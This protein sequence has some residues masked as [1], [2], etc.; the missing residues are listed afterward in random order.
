MI[1]LDL[2]D[3]AQDLQG[4]P[5]DGLGPFHGHLSCPAEVPYSGARGVTQRRPN[6]NFA[7]Q[8]VRYK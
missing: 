8:P 1:A 3:V 6:P 5:A 4:G 2:L 7:S